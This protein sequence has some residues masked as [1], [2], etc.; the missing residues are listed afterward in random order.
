M[1]PSKFYFLVYQVVQI[2]IT[3]RIKM[4]VYKMIINVPSKARY[5]YNVRVHTLMC[6]TLFSS[7]I[8]AEVYKF[9]ICN[10][11]V[12]MHSALRRHYA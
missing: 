6:I 7:E 4:I 10:S 8:Y 9:K 1:N 2:V 11:A 3:F 12:C 5:N